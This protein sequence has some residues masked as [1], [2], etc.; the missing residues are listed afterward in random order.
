M[1]SVPAGLLNDLN[2]ILNVLRE[3]N[4]ERAIQLFITLLEMMEAEP[5]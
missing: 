1:I 4:T 3:G 2:V 5:D